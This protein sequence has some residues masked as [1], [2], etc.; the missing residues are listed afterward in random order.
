M[1]RVLDTNVILN[2]A[3]NIFRYEPGDVI[4]IPETV[5]DELDSKKTVIGEIGFQAREFG[6][7]LAKAEKLPIRKI[8]QLV[9]SPFRVGEVEIVLASL[10]ED[11]PSYKD[12][13][14]S[15][16]ND[17]K[18]IYIAELYSQVEPITF[19]SIDVM[20]RTRAESLGL[21]CEDFKE[22]ERTEFNFIKTLELD[23][24]TFSNVHNEPILK[25]DP[26]YKHENYSYIFTCPDTTQQKLANIYNGN[27]DVLG[28]VTETELRNQAV[29]PANAEQ[30]F[31]SRALQDTSIDVV[32][33]EAKAGSGKTVTAFSNGMAQIH[34]NNAY[35]SLVYIRA[36]INDVEQIEE[37]G[38]L[39]GLDEK[40][41]GYYLPAMDTLEFIARK[42]HSNSKLKGV[43]FEQA[44]KEEV[45]ALIAKYRIQFM[46]GLN[47]RGRTFTN[48][49]VIID[50]VQGQS[51][52]SIQKMLTRFGKGCKVVIIGSQN[53]IDNKFI[54]KYN[55]G[56]SVLLE[57]STKPNPYIKTFAINLKRVLRSP[58]AEW[59]ENLFS[60]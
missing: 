41:A 18:I 58:L 56:L 48:C 11:Y 53:Q 27:V 44:I 24:E 28:R 20:C 54:T 37:V 15:I 36:S 57:D 40:F 50:E 26:D 49:F 14:P 2:N 6:R 30:L 12:T 32:I 55:N 19:V 25:I 23:F 8:N 21:T 4:V 51:N 46:T 5:V 45:E 43:A 17:R 7:I 60:K 1:V 16:I 31:L 10:A 47:M 39:P 38:F 35:E 13:S 22:V 9:L 3:N 34:R 29:P 52:S 59:A 42:K 33:C